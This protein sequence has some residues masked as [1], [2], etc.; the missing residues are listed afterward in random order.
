MWGSRSEGTERNVQ[1][2]LDIQ[3]GLCAAW[4]SPILLCVAGNTYVQVHVWTISICACVLTFIYMQTIPL[5]HVHTHTHSCAPAYDPQWPVEGLNHSRVP[6]LSTCPLRLMCKCAASHKHPH[7]QTHEH[8]GCHPVLH[9]CNLFHR[10][11]D[12]SWDP[13]DG[14]WSKN[15]ILLSDFTILLTPL[16]KRKHFFNALT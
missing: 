7:T 1:L 12:V 8:S 4:N 16:P 9:L 11:A 3:W 5:F 13:V 2:A 10:P 15:C 14:N 6:G